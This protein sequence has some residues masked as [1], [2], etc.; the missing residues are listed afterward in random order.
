MVQRPSQLRTLPYVYSNAR[1]QDA[2][3]DA[4]VAWI[5][6]LLRVEKCRPSRPAF[7]KHLY[8]CTLCNTLALGDGRPCF[9]CPQSAHICRHCRSLYIDAHGTMQ[10]CMSHQD[11]QSS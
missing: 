2:A 7:L 5:L 10:C 3:A 6:M 1:F 9:E 11:P 4:M 8:C